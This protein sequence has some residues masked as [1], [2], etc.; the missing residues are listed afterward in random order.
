MSINYPALKNRR[1]E[2][3]RQR[4]GA[5]DSIL[6]AL[7]IGM[8]A[9]PHDLNQLR[10]VYEEELLAMP[11]MAAVLGSPGFW[12]RAPDTGLD[13]QNM[14]HL[15]QELTLHQPLKAHGDV[16][17]KTGVESIV[18]MRSKGAL[19]T[20]RCDLFDATT[21]EL[22][23]S[24]RSSNLCRS[25]GHFGGGDK[26]GWPLHQLPQRLPDMRCDL[27]S[28]GQSALIYR[29]SGDANP[30][31][32]DIRV[33]QSAGFERPLL[34]GLGTF[35]MAGHA[36]LRVLC[37]YE[38]TRLKKLRARFTAPFYPGETLRTSF[39]NYGDGTAGFQCHA[40]ER[41]VMVI[42]NGWVEYS[43]GLSV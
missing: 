23:A 17:G 13:W 42:N 4:Y 19:L 32:A 21:S 39:W 31:H 3:V 26:G 14:L 36:A 27:S 38:P 37:N 20:T 16:V 43:G 6:Y 40:V 8:G 1:F 15:D 10:Y 28:F 5:S 18:D 30:L 12:M 22:I 9:D 34:H 7:G 33:A 11:T 35:G 29:L 25:D 2:D 24:T 41:D